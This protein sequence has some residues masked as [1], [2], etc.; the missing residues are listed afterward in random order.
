MICNKLKECINKTRHVV[1]T[2]EKGKKKGKRTAIGKSKEMD[3]Y[4]QP[5]CQSPCCSK[6]Q[7]NRCIGFIDCRS[8]PT[9]TENG[10]SYTLNQSREYPRHE[11]IKLR[12]DGGVITEPEASTLTKCDYALIIKD[13]FSNKGKKG[14]AILIE[15]KGKG[16]RHALEQLKATLHQPEFEAVWDSCARVFGRVVCTSVPRAY[17]NDDFIIL[18]EE[19]LNMGGRLLIIEKSFNEDYRNL[20]G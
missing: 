1:P 4:Q 11:V 5:L 15:L 6:T 16:I 17:S 8:Q 13:E 18:K 10:K 20:M 7:Q 12:I 14:T 19:F 9:C 2:D 3:I